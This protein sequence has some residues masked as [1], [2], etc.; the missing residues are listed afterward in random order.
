MKQLVLIVVLIGAV[1][2]GALALKF[3][4]PGSGGAKPTGGGGLTLTEGAVIPF[5]DFRLEDYRGSVVVMDFWAT[6]CGPCKMA[7]PGLQKLHEKYKDR[8]LV[9]LGINCWERGDP[10]GYMRNNNFTYGLVTGAD[11]LARQYSVQGIPTFI[12]IGIDGQQIHRASGFSPQNEH[13][14]EQVIVDHLAKHGR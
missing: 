6:W 13:A 1:A 10:V 5:G 11:E 4:G 14:L 3:T 7:M 9:V 8:G 2:A 12:V